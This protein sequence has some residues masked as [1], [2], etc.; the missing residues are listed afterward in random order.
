ML[1]IVLALEVLCA[2]SSF[3]DHQAG[4]TIRVGPAIGFGCYYDP[5]CYA[6]VKLC[7]DELAQRDGLAA[8]VVDVSDVARQQLVYRASA[9]LLRANAK[10]A[11]W[12]SFLSAGCAPLAG[13]IAEPGVALEQPVRVTIPLRAKWM[14]VGARDVKDLRWSLT[15]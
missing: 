3:G 10:A 4:G 11:S 13:G 5:Q 15:G 7:R 8:S 9:S 14:V 12:L 6:F 2:G 1:G